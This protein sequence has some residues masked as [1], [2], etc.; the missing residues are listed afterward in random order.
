MPVPVLAPKTNPVVQPASTAENPERTSFS[1][2][3][4]VVGSLLLIGI[5]A[6]VIFWK[7]RFR[8]K[9]RASLITRSIDR[10]PK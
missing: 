2:T 7:L 9:P 5:V 3:L 1:L 10:D 8:S 6:G 4:L